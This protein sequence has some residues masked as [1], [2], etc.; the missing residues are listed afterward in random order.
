MTVLFKAGRLTGLTYLPHEIGQ[1]GRIGIFEAGCGQ[2]LKDDCVAFAAGMI[3]EL[4]FTGA[5]DP[6]RS[7]DDRKQVLSLSGQPIENFALE[8]YEAISGN[9][10]FFMMLIK[11]VQKE[12]YSVLQS[13]SASGL[14]KLPKSIVVFSLAQADKVHKDAESALA[15]LP[16]RK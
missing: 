1:D 13:T 11:E 16:K 4:I 7:S 10:L 2:V 9:L 3:G 5:Y 14:A 8:A 6:L 15:K 12:M